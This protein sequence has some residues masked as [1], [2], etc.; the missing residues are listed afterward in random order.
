MPTPHTPTTVPKEQ[1]SRTPEAFA[2]MASITI[3]EM[4][5][6]GLVLKY[7]AYK[8]KSLDGVLVHYLDL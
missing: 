6:V 4:T 5:D 7:K 8:I 2:V 3:N 1:T